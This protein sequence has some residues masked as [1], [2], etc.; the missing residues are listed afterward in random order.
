MAMDKGTFE[1][2]IPCQ[3]ISFDFPNPHHSRE[4]TT[5]SSTY[6]NFLRITALDS[7]IIQTSDH[8]T[9]IAAML[10]PIDREDDWVFSTKSGNFQLLSNLQEISRLILVGNLPTG[11]LPVNY[12]R[13]PI[14]DGDR[15]YMVEFEE[16]L[17]PLLIAVSPKSYL[18]G[19]GENF[20]IPFAMYED[21]LI[22]SVLVE[23]CI[24][25]CVGEMI[26]EDVEIENYVDGKLDL[27]R[28]EF[29][30]R[31]RFKRM[32]N[33][34]QT[35]IRIVPNRIEVDSV[36][37]R[38]GE[39]ECEL[40]TGCLVHPYLAPMV[41]S[42]SLI[43]RN[44]DDMYVCSGLKLPKVL[45]AGIGGGALLTFLRTQFGFQVFGVENDE[46]VV[47]V[48][49]RYFGL[50]ES[51][52]LRVLVGDG[53]DVIRRV[54]RRGVRAGFVASITN[55]DLESDQ[56][57]ITYAEDESKFDIIMVDLDSN[58]A[59]NGPGAPPLDF[60]QN[61]ILLDAKLALNTLGIL[62]VNVIPLS[63]SFYE[64]LI[65]EL[66]KVFSQLYEINVGNEENY[67]IIATVSPVSFVH[68]E[69]ETSIQEK[70]K[71]ANLGLYIECMRKI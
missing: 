16:A 48:A 50:V 5:I 13:R 64:V 6:G 18:K 45:C 56:H 21:N 53:I 27:G 66:R 54:A 47:N 14:L 30:R 31:L 67:V 52:F 33:L 15:E 70:L 39:M 41:A 38:I 71:M 62:V 19:L 9:Q 12:S 11:D 29:R 22:C 4:S 44:L 25:S 34:V 61:S 55:A 35:E 59:M 2:L 26:V 65:C 63:K 1:N 49:K 37:L 51:E 10:V 60:V 20:E 46:M 32:P 28:R 17:L 69:I 8:P 58:D 3:Y 36:N 68:D 42:L 24:G 7:P 40:D 23:R 57:S 43:A